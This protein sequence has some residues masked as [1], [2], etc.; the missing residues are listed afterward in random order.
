LA[1][2]HWPL[3]ISDICDFKWPLANLPSK[4][5]AMAWGLLLLCVVLGGFAVLR[6][7]GRSTDFKRVK[8]E[9]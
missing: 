6:P 5:P 2:N 7:S 8:E 3:Q 4:E 9:D 1:I